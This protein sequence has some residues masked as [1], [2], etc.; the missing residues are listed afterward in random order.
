MA[1]DW[2]KKLEEGKTKAGEA[3]AKA[4]VKADELAD[5]ADAAVTGLVN[6][7]EEK[8]SKKDAPKNDGPKN[9]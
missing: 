4:V 9:G 5:K 3:F 2:K 1:F 7:L 8:I 6:K